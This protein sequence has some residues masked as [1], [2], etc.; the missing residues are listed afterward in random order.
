MD[1]KIDDD[2]QGVTS[3]VWRWQSV[4]VR[5]PTC[6]EEC[7]DASVKELEDWIK[8]SQERLITQVNKSISNK[9]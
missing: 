1:K 2:A 9:N 5:G 8:K 4:C 7:V 6:I 3:K